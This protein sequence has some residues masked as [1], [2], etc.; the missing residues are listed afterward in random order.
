MSTC[1]TC[2]FWKPYKLKLSPVWAGYGACSSKKNQGTDGANA[3]SYG[4][5]DA[6]AISSTG[7]KFGCIHHRPN[8]EQSPA[9]S[10]GQPSQP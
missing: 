6:S 3:P 10:A 2:K 7:P 1:D 8:S 4:T 5:D 9:R